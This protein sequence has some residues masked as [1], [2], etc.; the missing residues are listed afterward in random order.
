MLLKTNMEETKYK[1]TFLGHKIENK[2]AINSE[3][4]LS[5]ILAAARN[6]TKAFQNLPAIGL[7]TLLPECEMRSITLQLAICRSLQI[8]RSPNTNDQFI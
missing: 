3:S 8:T 5:L 2:K 4:V 7:R 6:V 1:G